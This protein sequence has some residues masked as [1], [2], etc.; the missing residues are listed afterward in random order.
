ML[1]MPYME[2]GTL[3]EVLDQLIDAQSGNEWAWTLIADMEGNT[4]GNTRISTYVCPSTVNWP[5][6]LPRRD[7]AGVV[8]GAGDAEARHPR[9]PEGV[10][11][12]VAIAAR[13][14]VFNNGIFNL[15]VSIPLQLGRDVGSE[16]DG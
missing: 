1:I 4:V 5:G 12:P 9:A 7:Y 11:Q 15:G 2:E 13:G 6:L 16:G 8:G 3:P 10:R 14:R